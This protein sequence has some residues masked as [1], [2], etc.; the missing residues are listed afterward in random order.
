MESCWKLFSGYSEKNVSWVC[1]SSRSPPPRCHMASVHF[2]WKASGITMEKFH[3][4]EK[5]PQASNDPADGGPRPIQETGMCCMISPLPVQSMGAAWRPESLEHIVP[6]QP[7][8]TNVLR[9]RSTVW[10]HT[11][12]KAGSPGVSV[13]SSRVW[14][15]AG[16]LGDSVGDV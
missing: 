11:R 7:M 9:R 15:F 2:Q 8:K 6:T 12:Q 14:L 1:F 16:I 5:E 10:S 4:G 13:W 3:F